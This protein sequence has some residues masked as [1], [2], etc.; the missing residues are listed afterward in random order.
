MLEVKDIDVFYADAQALYGVGL[1][2]E[3]GEVVTLVG[4]NGAGKTTTLRAIS[5]LRPISR[6]DLV[7]EG[8]SIAGLPA[9][10]RAELGI[11]LVPEGR[12]LWPSLTVL[13]NLELGCYS[14][15]ARKHRDESLERVFDLFPRLQERSKQVAGSMSG[16]EQQM[17]AIARALMTRP[18]LLMFDE[19][20]LG[21]APVIVTQVFSIIRRLAKE[22]L[23]ILLVE[24][25]LK[26]ALEVADRGYV[27]ETGSITLQGPA[28]ELMANE[29]I[30]SAYL[31]I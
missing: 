24:Q 6:G 19:P 11:A 1:R 4:S 20:S 16:G 14:K 17:V 12:E 25:N 7:F 9:H 22:G 13:E 27:V 21:L 10:G 31:G 3:E 29:G 5:G 2:V 30:R 23:T 28:G 18:R 15:T 26:K 8:S